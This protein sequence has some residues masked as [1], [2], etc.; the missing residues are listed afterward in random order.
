MHQYKV[1]DQVVKQINKYVK[2]VALKVGIQSKMT[3]YVARHSYTSKLLRSGVSIE[4]L[5]QQLG[6]TDSKTTL[7]YAAKIDH[8]TKKENSKLLT[9]F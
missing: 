1:K 7:S 8:D 6:H 3:T 9:V 5:R 4:F 2:R